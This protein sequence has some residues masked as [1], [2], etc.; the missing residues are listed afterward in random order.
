MTTIA[1][2]VA[3]GSGTRTGLGR[4]KQFQPIAGKPMVRHAVEAL[5]RHPRVDGVRVVIGPGQE[6]EF[7]DAIIGLPV[8]PPII[9]G[10][11]RQD[12]VRLGLHALAPDEPR[13]VLIH[14]AARPFCPPEVVDRLL[15]ALGTSDGAVPGLPATDTLVRAPGGQ[16]GAPVDRDGM[17]RLQTPQAFSFPIIRDMHERMAGQRFTDDVTLAREAGLLIAVVPGD[18]RLFKV[19]HPDDFA[20]AEQ[21]LAA[22]LVTRTG[23]GFDVHAFGG[24]G[25]VILGGIS[26]PHERGLA[27]HSDAD[28]VLHTITD[29]LLGAA[30]EGDIGHHFPPSD[31]RW[32]GAAS[33]HFLA[34]AAALIRARGGAIDFVDATVICEAP[35]IG[36]HREAM[37]ARIA[38]ILLLPV[39]RVSVKATTTERLGFTGRGEGIAAQ[40]VATIRMEDA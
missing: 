6:A 26:I 13:T 10:E 9:G 36:P 4:P 15:D 19:T 27:G 33:D 25:P 32:R 21:A 23:M 39:T 7:A 29:A 37:R 18:E 14:D 24:P 40:A 11:E 8:G 28:V 5:L 16:V 30:G 35:K 12:S 34:H 2:I 38:E 31:E 20:R 17:F 3:A 22:R 1:L